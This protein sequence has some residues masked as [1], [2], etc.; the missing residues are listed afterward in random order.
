MDERI[1]AYATI[2]SLPTFLDFFAFILT[3]GTGAL[4]DAWSGYEYF[5]TFTLLSS[6]ARDW[7]RLALNFFIPVLVLSVGMMTGQESP[8]ALFLIS[9]LIC[10]SVL[11]LFYIFYTVWL[12]T[13]SCLKII[14]SCHRDVRGIWMSLYKLCKVRLQLA[15]A[16]TS[17]QNGSIGK[18]RSC[19]YRNLERP[20]RIW[21]LENVLRPKPIYTNI[22]GSMLF[23]CCMLQSRFRGSIP[24]AIFDHSMVC[25]VLTALFVWLLV[26]GYLTYLTVVPNIVGVFASLFAALV[27]IWWVCS[28][29]SKYKTSLSFTPNDSDDADIPDRRYSFSQAESDS[30][31]DE[32]SMHSRVNMDAYERSK[33]REETRY[34]Y[35]YPRMQGALFLVS[36]QVLVFVVVPMIGFFHLG[37]NGYGFLYCIASFARL[38]SYLFDVEKL[39]EAYGPKALAYLELP[40]FD[41]LEE[42]EDG[43]NRVGSPSKVA[44]A[45]MSK[46]ARRVYFLLT[47]MKKRT[48]RSFWFGIYG[49]AVLILIILVAIS[50]DSDTSVSDY[51]GVTLL[52]N[53]SHKTHFV[54]SLSRASSGYMYPLCT[55]FNDMYENDHPSVKQPWHTPDEWTALDFVFMSDLAYTR[56][57][58]TQG[59]LDQWFAPGT[60]KYIPPSEYPKYAQPKRSS[61]V[62]KIF[63]V[64]QKTSI[65]H[66]FPKD[67]FMISIRGTNKPLDLLADMQ[68]WFPVMT[69]QLVRFI[70]PLASMWNPI[71][72]YLIWYTNFLETAPSSELSYIEDLVDFIKA[73]KSKHHG[74]PIGLTGHSLGGGVAMIIGAKEKIP[75]VAIS[76]PNSWLSRFKFGISKERLEQ[77]SLNIIPRGDPVP[78]IDDIALLSEEILCR[79]K[80]QEGFGLGAC[81]SVTRSLCEIQFVCG[82]GFRPPVADCDKYNY[83]SANHL[84]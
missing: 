53:S 55:L 79:A 17:K 22:S 43:E 63:K 71:L 77:Y 42:F 75:A 64:K 39:I 33:S 59:L 78:Q 11:F 52:G 67:L 20:R 49:F 32:I 28:I 2:L 24:K 66:P 6:F 65:L 30:D 76:G 1:A 58:T 13:Y 82:S 70:L 41:A 23:L 50:V 61:V 25:S 47:R 18:D 15:F 27:C 12:E 21:N 34:I 44:N 36:V 45:L 38:R 29:Y 74:S 37:T 8:V 83:P 16:L 46:A 51:A 7:V 62:F 54:P 35:A 73:L 19:L 72:P 31:I 14:Q 10:N 68:I 56:P 69:L 3:I 4:S 57:N 9:S 40:L 26:V 84:P 60:V 80:P 48:I 5:D 81:H